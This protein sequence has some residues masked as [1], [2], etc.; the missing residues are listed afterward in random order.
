MLVLDSILYALLAV[1][2]LDV[3]ANASWY[4]EPPRGRGQLVR[5]PRWEY[6]ALEFVLSL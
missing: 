4:S 3:I 5:L 2:G 6:L 1:T